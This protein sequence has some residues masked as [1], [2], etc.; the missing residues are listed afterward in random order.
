M[1]RVPCQN[2]GMKIKNQRR[3]GS[4]QEPGKIIAKFGRVRLVKSPNGRYKILEGWS[5][6]RA[7]VREWCGQYAPFVL[8]EDSID[9]LP[10]V[11]FA[12]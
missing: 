5:Y 9:C 10:V 11:A 7:L 2:R 6:E 4:L 1:S 3:L 12:E 8:F